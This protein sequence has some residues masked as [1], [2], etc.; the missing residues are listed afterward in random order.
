MSFSFIK[1][2]KILFKYYLVRDITSK[3]I[4]RIQRARLGI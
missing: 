4:I 2:N 1:Y 3:A